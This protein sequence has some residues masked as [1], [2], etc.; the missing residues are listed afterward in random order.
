[1]KTEGVVIQEEEGDGNDGVKVTAGRERFDDLFDNVEAVSE[2]DLVSHTRRIRLA[3]TRSELRR[4]AC[5][6]LQQQS[7]HAIEVDLCEEGKEGSEKESES[8]SYETTDH[9][10]AERALASA[11]ELIVNNEGDYTAWW[12][13]RVALHVLSPVFPH[14]DTHTHTHTHSRIDA[15][16]HPDSGWQRLLSREWQLVLETNVSSPKVYQAW[17][18]RRWLASL[19]YSRGGEEGGDFFT[20]LRRED[21]LNL[22]QLLADDSKNHNLWQYRGHL[23]RREKA[24]VPFS[25]LDDEFDLTEQYIVADCLNNS[26]WAYR[27]ALILCHPAVSEDRAQKKQTDDESHGKESAAKRTFWDKEMAFA[28]KWLARSEGNE[29][30]AAYF[31][32][33]LE[34]RASQ[35]LSHL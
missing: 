5:R 10:W 8:G 16:L 14:P 25:S 18:Q 35:N 11:A 23:M 6:L 29:A 22:E 17:S 13:R 4:R 15:L 26:V 24:L 7:S 30:V 33:L 32:S 31:D 9:E 19:I 12:I 2:E 3:E 28:Q 20:G 27:H 34:L 1:M 21:K